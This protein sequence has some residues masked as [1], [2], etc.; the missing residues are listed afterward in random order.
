[1]QQA[2]GVENGVAQTS[3]GQLLIEALEVGAFGQP[4]A[5]GSFANQAFVLAHRGAQLTLH[6]SVGIP[7][8]R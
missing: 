1:M 4:N 2:V 7:Q 8:Q 3:L 5:T 6:R